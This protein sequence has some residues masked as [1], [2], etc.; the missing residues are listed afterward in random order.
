M[1]VDYWKTL[2]GFHPVF[3]AETTKIGQGFVEY[4]DENGQTHVVECDDVVV[5]GGMRPHQ[6]EAMEL[7][8]TAPEVWR[9]GDCR[10]VGNLHTC[11]RSAYAA[12]A[13]I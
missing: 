10:Q 8:S 9:I 5:L 6:Q 11:S 2:D 7:S 1:M 13:Q 12:A 3:H 4:K